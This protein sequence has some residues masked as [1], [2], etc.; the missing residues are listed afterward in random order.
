MAHL[1]ID[2][3]RRCP[4]KCGA[5]S[6]GGHGS[7]RLPDVAHDV[8]GKDRLVSDEDPERR[9]P[10][11]IVGGDHSCYSRNPKSRRGVYATDTGVGMRTAHG[12]SPQHPFGHE[13]GG[14]RE[15]AA[16]L[17]ATVGPHRAGV[18]TAQLTGPGPCDGRTVGHPPTVTLLCPHQNRTSWMAW[19]SSA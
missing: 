2:H 1:V 12:H 18:Y 3:H 7:H 16:D 19:P 10:G 11:H 15:I 4:R 13:V 17:G 6:V 8:G 5:G 9:L 14:E